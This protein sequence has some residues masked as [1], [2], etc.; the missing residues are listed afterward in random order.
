MSWCA[1]HAMEFDVPLPAECTLINNGG[2]GHCALEQR[3]SINSASK[4]IV[5]RHRR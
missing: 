3:M 5:Q 1:S 4:P 2:R